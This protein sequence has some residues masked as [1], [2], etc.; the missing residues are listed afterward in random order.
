MPLTACSLYYQTFCSSRNVATSA[1]ACKPLAWLL[2]TFL[3]TAHPLYLYNWFLSK[4]EQNLAAKSTCTSKATSRHPKNH[5]HKD[6][7]SPLTPTKPYSNHQNQLAFF[8]QHSPS[9]THT[10]E[11]AQR[12]RTHS[13]HPHQFSLLSPRVGPLHLPL[14]RCRAE[15]ARC[16]YQGC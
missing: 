12:G 8:T 2:S 13:S 10:D 4:W 14:S 9:S 7:S 11:I 15:P 16:T 5:Q 3:H 1:Q 6:C